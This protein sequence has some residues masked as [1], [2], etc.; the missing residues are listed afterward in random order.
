MQTIC[1][2]YLLTK[3]FILVIGLKQIKYFHF[4]P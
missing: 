2:N 4:F 1:R 3:T